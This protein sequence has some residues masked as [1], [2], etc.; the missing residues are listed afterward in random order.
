MSW[1]TQLLD[2]I[3]SQD[4]AVFAYNRSGMWH[5]LLLPQQCQLS[6]WSRC[7]KPRQQTSLSLRIFSFP[8]KQWCYHHCVQN[9]NSSNVLHHWSW[10]WSLYINGWKALKFVTFWKNWGTNNP[11]ANPDQQQHC[12]KHCQ[13]LHPAKLH[14]SHGHLETIL[15][16]LE[17][18]VTNLADYLTKHHPASHH[19]HTWA[20]FITS[21]QK[22]LELCKRL[23]W[24]Q[25]SICISWTAARMYKY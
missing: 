15:F 9:Y 7:S 16:L 14:Q 19:C 8:I 23:H 4:P 2:Y 11:N 5:G 12:R 10:T 3:T 24:W 22:V 20:G 18:H 17:I 13:Q 21:F 25:S 1:L 6:Q